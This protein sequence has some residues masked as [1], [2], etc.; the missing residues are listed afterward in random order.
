MREE[1]D[2][3][4]GEGGRVDFLTNIISHPSGP[5][6]NSQKNHQRR[7]VAV[8]Q[9]V[10]LNVDLTIARLCSPIPLITKSTLDNNSY[11][12]MFS[13]KFYLKE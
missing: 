3:M 12:L 11:G 6:D 10:N 9:K 1:V 7:V 5:Q 13:L 2:V 8:S 4:R